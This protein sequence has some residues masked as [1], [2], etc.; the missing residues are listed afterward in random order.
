[1]HML[2]CENSWK[3]IVSLDISIVLKFFQTYHVWKRI[4]P[5]KQVYSEELVLLSGVPSKEQVSIKILF[6][7]G[8]T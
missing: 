1:M 2:V 4:S 6:H 8:F 5:L 7:Y 3:V